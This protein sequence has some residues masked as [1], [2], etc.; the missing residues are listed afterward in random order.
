MAKKTG[1]PYEIENFS[2]ADYVAFV[3]DELKKNNVKDKETLRDPVTGKTIPGVFVGVQ[4]C[5]KLFKTT[6]TNFAARG[7]EGPHDQDDAPVGSGLVGPKAIGGMEVNALFSHNARALLREGTVLRSGKN[8]EF[9]KAFQQG[10]T[11]NFPAEKK[12]FSRFVDILKQAGINVFR[13]GDALVAGPLTDRDILEL[14]SGEITDGRM[15]RAKTLQPEPDGLFDPV[16]TGGLSGTRWSHVTLAEPVL[17]PV[18]ADAARTML[19]LSTAGLEGFIETE[20]GNSLRKKLN[21]VD[22]PKELQSEEEQLASG[23]LTRGKL[24]VAVKRV[25]YL[26]ALKDLGLSPG[27]AYTLSVAPITPPV[28]RPITV[29][30]SGDTM[31][32]DANILY[33]DLILQNN[34]FKKILEAGLGEEDVRAN[35][36]A[37][38]TRMKELTGIM[39]PAS[40]HLRNRN[41]KGA[42]DF[43]AG[44][45]PKEGY[46][47][48]KVI[49]GKMNLSGRATISPDVTLGLDEIGLPEDMAWEMY[50]PFVLRELAGIG[51]SPLRAKETVESR[52]PIAKKILLEEL[53]KRPVV[54]NRAPTLW[55]HG[56]MS[57]KP[58]L[59]P[60]SNLQVNSLWE[61][62][63]NADYDGDAM[64]LHVPVSDEAIADALKM[65][66]SQQ[67]FSDKKPGD[68]LEMPTRE[69]IIGLYKVTENVGKPSA[70]KPVYRFD[71]ADEAWESYYAGKLK[72]T[73]FVE[74]MH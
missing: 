23:T 73:D 20:G 58:L 31:D 7:I 39:A 25:K 1:R 6:D 37:L 24:D 9:W 8:L 32:N 52:E 44:D 70:G 36:R 72:M 42:L 43:I 74:I 3:R 56:I 51:F 19:R 5:H 57:A 21:A 41:V 17:N 30:K 14:S 22:V 61:K 63:L 64:Q 71:T 45:V 68:L 50:K 26:R 18:F 53:E 28:V 48:R 4:H 55:R 40:P 47:Q 60:G 65:L 11:P 38:Y 13:K 69:P 16:V 67:L 29:G 54:T 10:H 12:T 2:Q 34:S 46:F 62:S 49:Y 33:R 35:R 59:R 27:D 66:P 15:L